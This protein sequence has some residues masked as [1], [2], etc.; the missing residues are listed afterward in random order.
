MKKHLFRIALLFISIYS[1]QAQQPKWKIVGNETFPRL[2]SKWKRSTSVSG[3]GQIKSIYADPKD[4]NHL[5]IGAYGG[6]VWE[7]FNALNPD[8]SNVK[9]TCLSNE[10]P[11]GTAQI[12][13]HNDYLYASSSSKIST[14]Y[15][16]SLF[17]KYGLGVVKKHKDATHW[18]VSN[19]KFDCKYFDLISHN[20]KE[21][22]YAISKNKVY[23]SIDNGVN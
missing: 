1:L 17:E 6:G 16:S 4:K 19:F 11:I 15:S 7:T 3:V 18:E 14:S 22:I 23:K 13:V 2:E 20:N 12:K 10:I 8:T 21:I 9:W 5:I